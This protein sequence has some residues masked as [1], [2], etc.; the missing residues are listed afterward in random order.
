MGIGENVG[1]GVGENTGSS[2]YVAAGAEETAADYFVDPAAGNDSNTGTSTGAAWL[3]L[4]GTQNAGDTA[5]LNTNS[6]AAGDI[7]EIKAGSSFSSAGSGRVLISSAYYANGTA[8]SPIII[9]TSSSWGFGDVTYNFTG[10]TIPRWFAGVHVAARNYIY[11]KGKSSS[12]LNL[13]NASP[14]TEGFAVQIYN[15]NNCRLEH[16]DETNCS[17]TGGGW[18][19]TDGYVSYCT[20]GN[21]ANGAGFKLGIGDDRNCDG[22][23]IEDSTAYNNGNST[24][25][26]EGL[27]HGWH[28]TYTPPGNTASATFRRCKAY[29]NRRDGFDSGMVGTATD[30]D[31]T[32][33]FFDCE[34]WDNGE[35]NFAVNGD[36]DATN[37][38]CRAYYVN[39]ITYNNKENSGCGIASGFTVYEGGTAYIYHCVA[40]YCVHSFGLWAL[41]GYT[42]Q[43]TVRNSI[44]FKPDVLAI[45]ESYDVGTRNIDVDYSLFIPVTADTESLSPGYDYTQTPNTNV[46]WGSNNIKGIANDPDF[47]AI[48]GSVYESNDFHIGVDSDCINQGGNL[49][50]PTEVDTDKDGVSRDTSPDIGVYEY[51]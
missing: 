41:S 18:W 32:T 38:V 21:N 9:R 8:E 44:S 46:T 11:I 3:N 26:C 47:T 35:D 20:F 12:K 27:P 16:C 23:V 25:G 30:S 45:D 40:A 42:T 7:I 48:S 37:A 31:I 39:C 33:Y 14:T 36:T 10:I 17:D 2:G 6:I 22:T 24:T 51:V 5:P 19:G 15:S 50:T 43:V 13:N 1:E 49:T 28:I 4:P 34:S 29:D